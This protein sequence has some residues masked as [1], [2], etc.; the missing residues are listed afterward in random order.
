ML[1]QV[2]EL[3]H[4]ALHSN[5][6]A[7]S[8]LYKYQHVGPWYIIVCP[9][10]AE[11]FKVERRHGEAKTQS[12]ATDMALLAHQLLAMARQH[13]FELRV[14]I[15]SGSAAGAVIGKL[16]AFYCIYGDTVNTASRLCKHAEPGQVHCSS[17]FVHYVQTEELQNAACPMRRSSRSPAPTVTCVSRGHTLLKG[18]CESI[19]TFVVSVAVMDRD[20]QRQQMPVFEASGVNNEERNFNVDAFKKGLLAPPQVRYARESN[21]FPCPAFTAFSTAVADS[22]R[23]C[24]RRRQICFCTNLARRVS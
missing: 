8:V 10:A 20:S 9:N 12:Y 4:S 24:R 21:K 19:E 14:G 2:P 13:G 6:H 3:F 16:R 5:L 15:H 23:M 1:E 22:T 18:F 17:G 11:P 7:R